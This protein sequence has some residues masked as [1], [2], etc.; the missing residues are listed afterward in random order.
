MPQPP[1]ALISLLVLCFVLLIIMLIFRRRYFEQQNKTSDQEL[2]NHELEKKISELGAEKNSLEIKLKKIPELIQSKAL[3]TEKIEKYQHLLIELNAVK[4]AAEERNNII[5]K[6]ENQLAEREVVVRSLNSK[7]A[8]QQ[9]QIAEQQAKLNAQQKHN[10]ERLDELVSAR[11]Q[12][13]EQFENIANKIFD[14]KSKVFGEKN[15]HGLDEILMPVREQLGEFR[16]RV[17]EIHT[18]DVQA[19]A[20]LTEH[21]KQLKSLNQEMNDEA[22]NLT[23]ALTGD[24]KA[25]GNWGE[26]VLEK[27]LEHSGLRKGFEYETQGSFRDENNKL[28]RPDVVIHLPENKDIIVDSKVSLVAYNRFI[29][30]ENDELQ[31][32]ALKD[33]IQAVRKHIADLSA[34]DYSGLEGIHSLDFV[35][36]FLP[37]ESAFI[38]AFQH[39]E[40]LFGDAFDKKIVVVTPTTLLATLR[41]IENIWR[42]ERQN[43]NAK[44]IADKASGIYDK[45]RGFVEDFEKIG[46]RI[47]S[48]QEGY[49]GALNKLSTGRGNLIK[50]AQEFIEL[51]V[52]VK[53]EMPKSITDND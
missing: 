25:Q 14:E 30:A 52:K 42:Y 48:V 53:K 45:L 12:L 43:E 39:D 10:Q 1:I 24:N 2:N 9:A 16:K 27:V 7:L 6:L 50:Q 15:R 37:I 40:K 22:R 20:G 18:Y 41:T 17:D 4:A 13:S 35:L 36:M 49:Q 5:P 38:T 26:M 51:G 32:A 47:N 21:L 29:N 8:A 11:Q 23:R 33:H 19:R 3:L 46:L 31:L 44:K 34:K 28:L